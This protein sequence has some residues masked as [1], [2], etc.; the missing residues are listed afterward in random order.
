MEE[1]AEKLSQYPEECRKS[2]EEAEKRIEE[3]EKILEKHQANRIFLEEQKAGFGPLEV[4]LRIHNALEK[5]QEEIIH[6]EG[7]VKNHRFY[8]ELLKVNCIIE[9][10]KKEVYLHPLRDFKEF[11]YESSHERDQSL[12]EIYGK[13]GKE[14]FDRGQLFHNQSMWKD[15]IADYRE[16]LDYYQKAGRTDLK[17]IY[18]TIGSCYERWADETSDPGKILLKLERLDHAIDNYANAEDFYSQARVYKAKAL[19][20]QSKREY[21]EALECL[22]NSIECNKNVNDFGGMIVNYQRIVSI[23]RCIPGDNTR[24]IAETYLDLGRDC[25]D[26]GRLE[27]ATEALHKALDLSV[28]EN[29][30]DIQA[31]ALFELGKAHLDRAQREKSR[32]LDL[33]SALASLR[34]SLRLLSKYNNASTRKR[35]I[36]LVQIIKFDLEERLEIYQKQF[37]ITRDLDNI[38]DSKIIYN[39]GLIYEHLNNSE[40]ARKHYNYCLKLFDDLKDKEKEENKYLERKIRESLEHVSS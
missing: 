19:I 21:Q 35:A 18:Y 10:L 31:E 6:L 27:K 25:Y 40:E 39:I 28:R 2:I 23:Y 32:W 7:E 11:G 22:V 37:E 33:L 12:K 36:S 8:K 3:L 13:L 24:Q 26:F 30:S 5:V 20:F 16:S 15:A 14:Y 1:S 34:D 38:E 29:Y 9:K 4:S 17:D